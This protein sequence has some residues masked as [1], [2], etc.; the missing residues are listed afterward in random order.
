M[1]G[2]VKFKQGRKRIGERKRELSYR[3]K[4]RAHQHEC[5]V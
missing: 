2:H 5:K 4:Q 3:E 1:V